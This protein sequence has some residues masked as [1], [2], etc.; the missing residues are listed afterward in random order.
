MTAIA[1]APALPATDGK[2][3]GRTITPL[4]IMLGKIVP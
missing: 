2:W 4:E 3:I 1:E